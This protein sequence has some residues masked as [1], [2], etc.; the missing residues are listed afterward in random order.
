[1]VELEKYCKDNNI[2]FYSELGIFMAELPNGCILR[3]GN[4]K[5]FLK[6]IKYCMEN[7][8]SKSVMF[9]NGKVY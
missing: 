6:D 9:Y 1:M 7:G 5:T 2:N 4:I 8:C 3:S